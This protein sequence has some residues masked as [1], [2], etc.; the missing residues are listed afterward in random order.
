MYRP[1]DHARV[2]DIISEVEQRDLLAATERLQE[3]GAAGV[4]PDGE[5]EEQQQQ[6]PQLRGSDDAFADADADDDEC[7]IFDGSS[8]LSFDRVEGSAGFNA[9]DEL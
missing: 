5:D 4:L 2:S 9:H 3:T 8:S 1:G 6:Q 7:S